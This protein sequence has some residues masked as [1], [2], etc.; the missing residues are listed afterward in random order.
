MG[1]TSITLDGVSHAFLEGHWLFRSISFTFRANEVYGLTGPSGSG[2]SSL[3]GILAGWISPSEGSIRRSL[4]GATSW[5]LQNPHG[6]PG[7]TVL[8]H[9]TLPLLASGM[10]RAEADEQGLIELKKFG[11]ATIAS[12]SFSDLSGGEAQRLMLARGLA[13]KPALLLVDEPTAQLDHAMGQTVNRHLRELRSPSTIV[14]VATHDDQTMASCSA[15]LD[16]REFAP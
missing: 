2:K 4:T 3:L 12:R 11:L 14:V 16:L 13:R 5:V 6:V 10:T 8:D 15:V 7:R 9:V 1:T